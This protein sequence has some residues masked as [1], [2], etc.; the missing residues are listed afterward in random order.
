MHIIPLYVNFPIFSGCPNFLA[1]IR[2]ATQHTA[3][4]WIERCNDFAVRNDWRAHHKKCLF[5][6][7]IEWHLRMTQHKCYDRGSHRLQE[8]FFCL[9]LFVFT[10]CHLYGFAA[11][12]LYIWTWM[13]LFYVDTDLCQIGKG[14]LELEIVI[15]QKRKCFISWLSYAKKKN[16]WWRDPYMVHFSLMH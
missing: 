10:M 15:H 11:M 8:N 7:E 1:G 2:I 14:K 16:L 6:W 9:F 4:V 13:M 12:T 5:P 3:K